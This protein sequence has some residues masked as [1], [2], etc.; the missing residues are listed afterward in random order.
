MIWKSKCP[1]EILKN[2]RFIHTKKHFLPRV[3]EALATK[4][5]KQRILDSS[6]KYQIGGQPGHSTEAHIY[7]IKSVW[8]MLEIMDSGLIITLVNIVSFF[9]KEN[10]YD[11]MQTLSEI[12][13]NKKAARVWFKLNEGTEISVKTAGGVSETAMV[14]DCI[15]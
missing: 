9:D 4:K 15:G 3:C 2:S 1:P 14:G 12:G 7:T 5:M 10:I 11:V 8:Q 6:T 13:V